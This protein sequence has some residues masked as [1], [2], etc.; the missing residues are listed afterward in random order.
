[1]SNRQLHSFYA[2]LE[3][4]ICITYEN[5]ARVCAYLEKKEEKK[6]GEKKEKVNVAISIR[7][8]SEFRR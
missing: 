8:L 4:D 5:T 3:K 2:T 7:Y 1:M 6:K